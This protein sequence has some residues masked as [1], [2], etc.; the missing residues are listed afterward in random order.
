MVI[1]RR[2]FVATSA[3]AVG[4]PAFDYTGKTGLSGASVSLPAP[5]NAPLDRSLA[6]FEPFIEVEASAIRHNVAEVARLC[7]GRPILAVVKNNGYGLGLEIVGPVLD[8][9]DQVAGLAVVKPDQAISLRDAGVQ[10]PILLMGHFSDSDAEELIESGIQ[11]T[12]YTDEAVSTVSRLARDRNREVPVHLYLDTGMNRVGVPFRRALPWIETIAADRAM[13]IESTFTCF[14]EDDDFDY[15]QLRRLR[16]VADSAN[17]RGFNIGR[18]HAASS[19]GVFFRPDGILEMVRP[20]LVLYGAY[21]A[22][23]I[24]T[25]MAGLRAALR[26]R[27]R[28]VRVERLETG[29]GV[30]YGRNYIA[31]KPTWIATLPIG[32]ADGYPRNAINGCEIMIRGSLYKVIGAVSASHTI[33]ELGSEKTAEIG[34]DAVLTGP[35]DPAILPNTVAERSGTSVYDV[36]M[37]LNAR[38][39]KR[40][41]G[42]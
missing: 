10:K 12:P 17:E 19:H 22:G 25:N 6:G 27:A 35:D 5:R 4:V 33:V 8:A 30:S 18:L 32:H 9:V 24:E 26:L 34:D 11:L 31:D 40:I 36:L 13:R 39:P 2:A 42:V 14:T 3:A 20:G 38:L 21:P 29:D 15:T 23:G 37:H 41:V 16:D 1:S 7:S 28:V